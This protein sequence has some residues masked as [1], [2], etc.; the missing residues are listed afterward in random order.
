[1][2]RSLIPLLILFSC[3]ATTPATSK[4]EIYSEIYNGATCIPY[5]AFNAANAVP[6][7]NWLLGFRD[8]A[9]CHFPVPN[10]WSAEQISYVVFEGGT[11]S[12]SDL[13]R[14][15]LCMYHYI[16]TSCGT[17]RT[18]SG[19]DRVNWVAPPAT[20]PSS[21]MGAY[22]SVSFP[23]GVV[24][25]FTNY[26]PLWYRTT[27]ASS[28]GIL[29]AADLAVSRIGSYAAANAK[30]QGEL[31]SAFNAEPRLDSWAA[32]K[33]ST[34]RAAATRDH[35]LPDDMLRTIECRQTRCR[36]Q[37]RMAASIDEQA[38]Q[39]RLRSIQR[40][41]ESDPECEFTVLHELDADGY[42]VE[43]L[44]SCDARRAGP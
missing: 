2:K 42:R 39:E 41:A 35:A 19:S 34:L 28:T 44:T 4:A 24:S 21:V 37:A 43:L 17:E 30:W 18:I 12:S 20:M 26:S 23:N 14:V 22:M 38:L 11:P 8:R 31:R 7:N 16:S 13:I 27:T 9:F 15:R 6:S 25:F 29:E 40:W 5:P 36:A 10:T 32:A 1:M 33:E 3:A